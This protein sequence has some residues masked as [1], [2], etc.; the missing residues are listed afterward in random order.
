MALN[1]YGRPLTEVLS[2]K[3]LGRVL[4]AS[5]D[6][7]LEVIRNLRRARQKWAQLSR[8]LV[9]EGVD[10]QISGMFY[11]AVVQALI[12]YRSETW[13][14]SPRIGKTLGGLHHRVVW[15]LMGQMPHKKLDRTWTHPSLE[16]V[17]VKAGVQ[18]VET[19]VGHRQNTVAKFITTKPI[20]DLC[21]AVPQRPVAQGSKK[22]CKQ[23]GM[24]LERTQDV[25]RVEE[26]KR[27]IEAWGRG[28]KMRQRE[29]WINKSKR[30]L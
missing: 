4:S 8:V 9:Q 2:F 6:D 22:W 26:A 17:M 15:R 16:E 28:Q 18:E 12:I 24:D 20:M 14:M 10:A 29:I 11:I 21:L 5:D 25:E 23:E 1:A 3:Y 7:W 13:V 19:Y 30:K 27:S